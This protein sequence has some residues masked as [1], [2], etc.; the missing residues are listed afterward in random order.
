[1]S[2]AQASTPSLLQSALYEMG[3]LMEVM[4]ESSVAA[5]E[6][7]VRRLID[8]DREF[9]QRTDD[10]RDGFYTDSRKLQ[11]LIVETIAEGSPVRVQMLD[12]VLGMMFARNEEAARTATEIAALKE[13][14]RDRPRV[15]REQLR[16]VMETAYPHATRR[17]R[18]VVGLR[19]FIQAL[20]LVGLT[21]EEPATTPEGTPDA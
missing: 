12:L 5:M 1:M 8:Q 20:E 4:G 11:N 16:H 15:S 10:A 7:R 19:A 14:L 17:W 21:V 13:Q 18:E 3:R 9:R 6:Y 2:G